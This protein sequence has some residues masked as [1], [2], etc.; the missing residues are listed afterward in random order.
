[1][2]RSRISGIEHGDRSAVREEEACGR[3]TAP[4]ETEHSDMFSGVV[5]GDHRNFK[6]ASP[7][8]AKMTERIQKRTMTVLS[9]QPLSSK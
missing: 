5:H 4:A 9:F 3:F 6:V 7:R 2:P 1:M 8:R